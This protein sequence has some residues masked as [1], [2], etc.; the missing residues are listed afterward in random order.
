MGWASGPGIAAALALFALQNGLTQ[1][2][3]AD[4]IDEHSVENGEIQVYFGE[5]DRFHGR[6]Q[7]AAVVAAAPERIWEVLRDCESA[8]DYLDNVLSCE[9]VASLDDG[10][11]AV[12]RQRARLRWFLPSFEHEFR[13]D[14]E[15]Y[16]RITISRVS[17]PLKRL[18]AVWW[19]IP[20]P[21]GRTRLIYRLDLDAGRA[22]PRF[23]LKAPL[24]RDIVNAL[25]MVRQRSERPS[26]E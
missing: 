19:L 14:F 23:L 3:E 11:S 22:V 21:D 16:R 7:A 25:T 12:F 2:P 18:D 26:S 5:E 20:E 10:R 1:E 24:R 15:P 4:W 9:L 17:G 13:M 8:P 6:A